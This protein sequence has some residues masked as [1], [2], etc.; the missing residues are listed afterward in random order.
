MTSIKINELRSSF[1]KE[2]SLIYQLCELILEKSQKPS[3][4][5]A[6]LQTLLRFLTWIPEAYIFQTKMIETL[7]GKFFPVEL[8]QNSTLQC[9]S[10]ISSLESNPNNQQYFT[11]LFVLFMMQIEKIVPHTYGNFYLSFYTSLTL[12]IKDFSKNF[13]KSSSREQSFV[14]Y[15]TIFLTTLF[16]NHLSNFENDPQLYNYIN[17]AHLYLANITKVPE[18]EIFKITL[19]YWKF[20]VRLFF[21]FENHFNHHL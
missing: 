15:F 21:L 13:N 7:I 17:I 18:L 20:L 14:N 12:S 8:F 6:T 10:E 1:V 11:K 9:L 4:I 5:H 19:E 3:L 2:F 16:R